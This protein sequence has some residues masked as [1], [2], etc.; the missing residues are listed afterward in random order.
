MRMCKL[1][2]LN[3]LKTSSS[4]STHYGRD[5]LFVFKELAKT[6]LKWAFEIHFRTNASD[7]T[8]HIDQIDR[9]IKIKGYNTDNKK[10]FCNKNLLTLPI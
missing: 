6:P 3:L 2:E 7:V 4:P 9:Q 10:L 8:A 1:V 5:L